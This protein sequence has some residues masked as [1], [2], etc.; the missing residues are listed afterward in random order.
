MVA[1]LVAIPILAVVG[2]PQF[3]PATSSLDPGAVNVELDADLAQE[4]ADG[5]AETPRRSGRSRAENR[6]AASDLFADYATDDAADADRA[7]A[8]DTAL[9]EEPASAAPGRGRGGSGRVRSLPDSKAELATESD[10]LSGNDH[11]PTARLGS[12]WEVEELDSPADA[13]SD[14]PTRPLP[15]PRS[16]S[17]A[18]GRT[19]SQDSDGRR[20]SEPREPIDVVGG[21][22]QDLPSNRQPS[23]GTDAGNRLWSNQAPSDR[24]GEW[25]AETP[26]G[27][28]TRPAPPARRTDQIA[29]TDSGAID[30]LAPRSRQ[31]APPAPRPAPRTSA[32]VPTRTT[33]SS[34]AD[35]AGA[36]RSPGSPAG[37]RVRPI[38]GGAPDA[39][40]GDASEGAAAEPRGAGEL[41][42][43]ADSGTGPV[44][45]DQLRQQF[46]DPLGP[47]SP[48]SGA[49][50]SGSS[51][52]GSSGAAG[53][54]P[55]RT[56]A[57]SPQRTAE[58]APSDRDLAEG[59]PLSPVTA[60]ADEESAPVDSTGD[61]AVD[62]GDAG[63]SRTSTAAVVDA[64]A[65]AAAPVDAEQLSWTQ[66]NTRLKAWG[67][68]TFRVRNTEDGR[69]V[70]YCTAPDPH[71]AQVTRRFEAEA[72]SPLAAVNLA[73]AEIGEWY[74][75]RTRG[76]R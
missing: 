47:G 65:S 49:S 54:K 46:R 58:F 25:E 3:A 44:T 1:P 16:V 50:R 57:A 61:P 67:I 38:P 29:S 43:M 7:A 14:S 76:G 18:S 48:G 34:A 64:G 11:E 31:P 55:A 42:E 69:F 45:R 52:A 22:T 40:L 5:K 19:R 15:S 39:T 73:I 4:P 6:A 2:I 66:A 13:G 28:S 62:L 70:F 51:A 41:D 75:Q 35:K 27:A 30:F 63:E 56:A 71:S 74:Q 53:T 68:K 59:E 24:L 17:G 32:A 23:G 9:D 8:S 20:R 36:A 72:D 60:A 33:G 37:S 10:S 12:D 21:D 26:S